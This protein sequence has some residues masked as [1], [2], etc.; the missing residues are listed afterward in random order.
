MSNSFKRLQNNWV[1][2]RTS[3]DG[4]VKFFKNLKQPVVKA[5]LKDIMSKTAMAKQMLMGSTGFNGNFVE[6]F[7]YTFF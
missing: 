7:K 5:F 3:A 6:N 1:K 2:M 4:M